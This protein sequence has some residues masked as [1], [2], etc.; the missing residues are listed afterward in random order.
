MRLWVGDAAW[1]EPDGFPLRSRPAV[2]F[3]IR[4]ISWPDVGHRCDG[5]SRGCFAENGELAA[6]WKTWL[7]VALV[8]YG[9]ILLLYAHHWVAD[10]QFAA[11]V[12]AHRLRAGLRAV[13][14]GDR[15]SGAGPLP[16]LCETQLRLLHDAMQP[17]AYGIFLTHYISS[18]GSIPTGRPSSN[19]RSCTSAT[20]KANWATVILLEAAPTVEAWILMFDRHKPTVARM[21]TR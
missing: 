1:F 13:Q 15:P 12:L 21:R 19:S 4:A 6:R 14:R 20:P 7:A 11:A 5:S 16:P 18:S 8:F 17:S 2:S 9:A 10:F 3:S